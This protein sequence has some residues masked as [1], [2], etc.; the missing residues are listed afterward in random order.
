MKTFKEFLLSELKHPIDHID[1][2]RRSINRLIKHVRNDP[3]VIIISVERSPYNVEYD[4]ND[5]DGQRKAIE[6]QQR[7]NVANTAS[8]RRGLTLFKSGYIPVHGGYNESYVK[9]D[10]ST[11][12][13]HV[14][15]QSTI[16]YCTQR[17]KDQIK[18][19]CV[20]WAERTNQE[21]ILIIDHG[22]GCFYN[23][24]Q[25]SCQPIGLFYPDKLGDYYT[26]LFG[27]SFTMTD[28]RNRITDRLKAMFNYSEDDINTYTK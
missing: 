21:S 8:F 19:F 20:D 18:Q 27:K 11:V 3:F 28:N 13:V 4:H 16:V 2:S 6:D 23:V 14:D 9:Q 15:E 1:E 10:G 7:L 5:I 12:K 25:R 22:K 26:R 24:K 17:N